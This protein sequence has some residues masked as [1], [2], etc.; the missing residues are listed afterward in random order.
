MFHNQRRPFQ[1]TICTNG[2]FQTK[3]LFSIWRDI[4]GLFF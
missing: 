1:A 2:L 3:E 4:T